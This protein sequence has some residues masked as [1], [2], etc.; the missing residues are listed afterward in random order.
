MRHC[1]H[2]DQPRLRKNHWLST[3]YHCLAC[4]HRFAL[5]PRQRAI[6]LV[7]INVLPLVGVVAGIATHSLL[8]FGMLTVLVPLWAY[9]A[10]RRA[11]PLRALAPLS[12][13]GS[14]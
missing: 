7:L 5:M 6:S 2:C 13:Q 14:S 12:D 1:P 9:F 8:V 3:R 4:G 10:Y 11:A